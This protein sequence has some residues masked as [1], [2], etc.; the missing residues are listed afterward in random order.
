M[1]KQLISECEWANSTLRKTLV[2][3][4][5]KEQTIQ[6]L[7]L[8]NTVLSKKLVELTEEIARLTTLTKQQK[9]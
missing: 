1:N 5:N 2:T 7:N 6:S 4:N 3:L 9:E 8:K